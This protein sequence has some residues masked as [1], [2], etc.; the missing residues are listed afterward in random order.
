MDYGGL[1]RGEARSR[2]GGQYI[3][4]QKVLGAKWH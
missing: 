1:E 4:R 3:G 2:L